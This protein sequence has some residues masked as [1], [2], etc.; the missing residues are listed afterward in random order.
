MKKPKRPPKIK[1]ILAKHSGRIFSLLQNHEIVDF[2]NQCNKAYLHWDQLRFKKIPDNAKPEF[3]WILLKLF[4]T[5]QYKHFNFSNWKFNF[6]LLDNALKKLHLLDKGAAGRLETDLE[7]VNIE[8][9]NK[10]IISSIMEEAIASSQ[11]EGAATTRRIAKE[12]LRLK[13]KPTNY[14]EKL[15]LNGFQT[16]Q[17]ITKLKDVSLTPD[18]ILELHREITEG[19]LKNKKDEGAFR[20]NN[21]TVVG[22]LLSADKIYHHPPD[23][24]KIPK[25]IDT[26]CNFANTEQEFIHP[27]IKG[28]ILHFLIGYIH[29]FN[30]GNGRTARTIFYW[31]VLSRGYWLF[32]FMSIS[33]IILRSKTKY[34]LAYLYTETD[35]NDLTYFINFNLSAIEEALHE[36]EKYI[37]RKQKEQAEAMNLIRGIK[38]INLRQAEILKQFMKQPEKAFVIREIMST[39]GIAYDTARNDLLHLEKLDF[40]KKIK[41]KKKYVFQLIK[42]RE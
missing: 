39:Y 1:E 25:L 24:K 42:S 6:I 14:S 41:L 30:D 29:P 26:F 10:F 19:T 23:Y 27:I 37:E 36:M 34:A 9:R 12:M 5:Q 22:D 11:L 4:R 8:G 28:I 40:I 20:D 16:M 13:K 15:I 35:E 38:N 7:S 31:Y 2:I 18:L 32:E 21:E 17:K 33:K 3:I